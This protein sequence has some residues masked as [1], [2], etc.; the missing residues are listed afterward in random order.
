MSKGI[1][2]RLFING[3]CGIY[4][5]D[6]KM[7]AGTDCDICP[8]NNKNGCNVCY[9]EDPEESVRIV[10]E[11]AKEH[12]E[13]AEKKRTN[14]DVLL[15]AFPNASMDYNWIPYACPGRIDAHYNCDKFENCLCCR[16]TYWLSEVEK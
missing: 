13:E 12:P 2:R 5:N 6:T 14:K 3:S 9:A 11:W 7:C 8:L 4:Q 10:E 15:A 16:H 1:E